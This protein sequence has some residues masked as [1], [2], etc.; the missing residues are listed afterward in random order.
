MDDKQQP[1]G[2]VERIQ[3][4][5]KRLQDI[6]RKWNHFQQ[7]LDDHK[8]RLRTTIDNL[9]KVIDLE[10]ERI[11]EVFRLRQ[12]VNQLEEQLRYL[13]A[14]NNTRES[15]RET[16]DQLQESVEVLSKNKRKRARQGG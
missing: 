11:S 3:T 10:K 16:G 9:R 1:T 13:Q 5:R 6:E 7:E 2:T 8:R 4:E 14:S 15:L 12:S